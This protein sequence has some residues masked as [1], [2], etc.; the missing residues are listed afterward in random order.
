MKSSNTDLQRRVLSAVRE[1]G[2][3]LTIFRNAMSEW[4]GVNPT[5]MECLRQL[6]IKGQSTPSELARQTGLTSGAATAMLDRLE[7]GGFIERHPNP[8]DR[9]GT[10]I[11]PV[12]ASGARM[13]GWFASARQAQA[14][15]VSTFSDQELEIIANAFERFT[16]LWQQEREKIQGGG[17]EKDSSPLKGAGIPQWG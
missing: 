2:V 13:A 4:A 1:Y 10:I 9:R 16:N 3:N 6:F 7:K 8:N 15:L 12:E 11:V 14:E 17:K 5:D